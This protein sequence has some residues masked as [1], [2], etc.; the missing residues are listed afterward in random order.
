MLPEIPDFHVAEHSTVLVV[1]ELDIDLF[2][3]KK[4]VNTFLVLPFK[5]FGVV[6]PDDLI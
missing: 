3:L 5:F 6:T 2:P 1:L 4:V